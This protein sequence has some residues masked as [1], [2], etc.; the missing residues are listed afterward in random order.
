MRSARLSVIGCGAG[1]GSG[2][3]GSMSVCWIACTLAA[4]AKPMMRLAV[5]WLGVITVRAALRKRAFA[6]RQ[7]ATLPSM[8][9]GM[10]GVQH[11]HWPGE[12]SPW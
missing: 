6:P 4:G 3:L 9:A 5:S 2:T 8:G 10:S 12:S 1:M 11:L 7:R